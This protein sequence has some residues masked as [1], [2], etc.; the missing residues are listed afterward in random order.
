M[1]E[2]R[3]EFLKTAAG[4]AAAI[5]GMS[6]ASRPMTLPKPGLAVSAASYGI[7][8]RLSRRKNLPAEIPTFRDPR[9]F[10]EHCHRLG[11]SGV[12]IG[13]RDWD[14]GGM[15]RKVR[16]KI[17][18]YGMVLEGQISL[19]KKREELA[20][21]V[22]QV[23]TA[24]EAGV[25]IFR[26]VALGG[27]RYETFKSLAQWNEFKRHSWD[28]FSW[29]EPVMKKLGVQLAVEN[30]KDW[31]VD[32]MIDLMR[33]LSSAH[34]GVNLDTGNNL[35]L[36][37][38]GMQAVVALAP[39]TITTHLKD[40]GVREYE[41][42]FQL[43]EVP[44]GEGHLDIRRIVEICRWANPKVQ[45]NLEMITRDPLMIPCLT[46]EYWTTWTNPSRSV[47]AAALARVRRNQGGKPLP[48]VSQLDLPAQVAA[49]E[50]N[51]R[52]CFVWFDSTFG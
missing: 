36:L 44:F 11:A 17:E 8:H 42:G 4:G 2:T 10:I 50:E 16:E 34:V 39:Y 24:K 9:H 52:R 1:N 48:T 40:M 15:A 25:L 47:L 30:H 27:R 35:S 43:A 7:R 28:R 41:D 20:E 29:A 22:R 19:P 49:E 18:E 12:Q 45:F 26:T 46:E 51:N 21:F 3:R 13:V 5:V 33:R 6:C 32:E 14:R 23:K 31:R 37:D 38:D